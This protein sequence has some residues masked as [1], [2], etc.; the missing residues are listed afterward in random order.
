M[1]AR[2]LF[3]NFPTHTHTSHTFSYGDRDPCSPWRVTGQSRDRP[4]SQQDCLWHLLLKRCPIRNTS[5]VLL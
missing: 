5:N 2:V 4:W 1:S 3:Q